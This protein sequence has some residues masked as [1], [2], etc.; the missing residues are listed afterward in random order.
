M[1]NT[2]D[3]AETTRLRTLAANYLQPIRDN[4]GAVIILSGF[5]CSIVNVVACSNGS[6]L[7]LQ[8]LNLERFYS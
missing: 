1:D 4:F 7:A 6:I 8:N 3:E 2:P 5:R